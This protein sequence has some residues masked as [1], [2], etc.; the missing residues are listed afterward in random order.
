MSSEFFS[1]EGRGGIAEAP[2]VYTG[3]GEKA[4]PEKAP[5]EGDNNGEH[6]EYNKQA[7][8][9]FA[10]SALGQC[11]G[12]G[13]KPLKKAEYRVDCRRKYDNWNVCSES[14]CQMV[15]MPL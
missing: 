2:G 10:V 14:A 6:R 11:F 4:V 7:A 8:F 5:A 12:I 15:W 3:K 13:L 9:Q 1:N